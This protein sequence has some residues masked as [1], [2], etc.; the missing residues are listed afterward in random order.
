MYPFVIHRWLHFILL[1]WCLPRD[2]ITLNLGNSWNPC[3]KLL[4]KS[5]SHILQ[6][7]KLND[8]IVTW[9]LQSPANLY[10][11]LDQKPYPLDFCSHR[12]PTCR[13]LSFAT[14]F[15][16][17][18]SFIF[19]PSGVPHLSLPISEAP[20]CDKRK[21]EPWSTRRFEIRQNWVQMLTQSPNT[22]GNW[23]KSLNSI[24]TVSTPI[25]WM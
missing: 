24:E 8:R 25:V 17:F 22:C 16:P 10:Q 4:I 21:A 20:W 9:H 1:W 6:I 3:R 12:I 19:P 23:D 11:I 18:H 14:N 13:G 7:R 5:D 15:Y 2:H